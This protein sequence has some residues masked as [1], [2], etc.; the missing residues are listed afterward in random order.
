LAELHRLRGETIEAEELYRRG[1]RWGRE[2]Q[3]GLALLRLAQ[4]RVEAAARAIRR[5]IAEAGNPRRRALDLAAGVEILLAVGDRDGARAAAAELARLAETSRAPFLRAQ[6]DQATGAVLLA[7]GD[8]AG[9]ITALHGAAQDWTDLRAPYE[10]AQVRALL[11]MA[12]RASG[13][14]DT[15]AI[16]LDAASHAF[17]ALG[18]EPDRRRVEA[19]LRP[20]DPRGGSAL[21][22][23]EV[24]VLRLVATGGTNRAVAQRLRISEK[25]VARH[26]SNIFTKL[27]L[28]SRAAA[29]AYAYQHGLISASTANDP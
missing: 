28:S 6:S 18:A 21:T 22:P 4:G 7:D 19:L 26:L 20:P 16:E 11:G 24:E 29:T 23:R 2:P 9:A 8:V 1:S 27:D 5:V 10:T 17:T 25:T 15:A 14:E 13:D 3:P 12:H